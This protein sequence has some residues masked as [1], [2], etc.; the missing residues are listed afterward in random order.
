MGKDKVGMRYKTQN[1]I[2]FVR[3]KTVGNTRVRSIIFF[4]VV[5]CAVNIIALIYEWYDDTLGCIY[6][7]GWASTITLYIIELFAYHDSKITT[8][9]KEEE[10]S[11]P[12]LG[13]MN[14]CGGI[15]DFESIDLNTG[16][17]IYANY[18]AFWGIPIIFIGRFLAKEVS[19]DS[20]REKRYKVYCQINTPIREIY[21]FYITRIGGI[22]TTLSVIAGIIALG[23]YI[24]L[25]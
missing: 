23:S 4:L 10:T 1:R 21:H 6:I 15:M 24:G 11:E 7:N 12:V 18:I 3:D 5:I 14:M 19:T 16:L 22:V 20:W 8:L 25:W 13:T 2:D 9:K 17:G